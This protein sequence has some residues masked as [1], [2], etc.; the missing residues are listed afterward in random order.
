M[1]VFVTADL[2]LGHPFVARLRGFDDVDEHDDTIIKAINDTVQKREKIWVLGD[3]AWTRH[4]LERVREI[5]CKTVVL[6]PG[7]HDRMPARRYLEFFSGMTGCA[8]DRDFLLS[9][10]PI[11]R[12]CL[13][14]YKGNLHGHIH[15][16][17]DES[18]GPSPEGPY[19]NVNPEFTPG[20]RPLNIDEIEL[21]AS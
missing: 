20:M 7:N 9:H 15:I 18:A 16:G 14:R 21:C 12:S 11:H 8:K 17:S 13:T 19:R 6:I 1:S 5:V 2:H 10:M 4:G 3:V